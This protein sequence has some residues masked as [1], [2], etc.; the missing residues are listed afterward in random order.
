M[1]V[2]ITPAPL[3]GTI[4]AIPSKSHLHRLLICAALGDTELCLPCPKLSQDIEATV[5]C[6][7]AL[8]AKVK[9]QSNELSV[10]PIASS[11]QNVTLDCGE[12]GSLYRFLVPVIGALNKNAT[13]KLSGKLPERPM[14]ALWNTLEAHGAVITG[15]GTATPIV[16]GIL[17]SGRYEIP[18]DISSQFISGLLFALPLLS[19]DSEIVISGQTQSVGYIQMTLDALTAFS[20]KAIPTPT[21]FSIPGNQTYHAINT[22]IP[23]GDWSNSAFWLCAAACSGEIT[24]TGLNPNSGQGDKAICDILRQFG[25]SVSQID[26]AVTVR[27]GNLHGITIDAAD[28]PDLVPALA[29][30][31]AAADGTTT[32]QNI[33]RLRLKESDRV[34]TVCG[35]IN[36]LGGNA[37]S[38]EN[39]ITIIGNGT[40]TGGTY[41]AFQDHRIVMAAAIASTICK[42]PVTVTNAQAVDKSYPEFFSDFSRLNGICRER[43]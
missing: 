12:S 28:I 2:T 5:R 38:N 42:N 41:D 36:A 23:E 3:N 15:K 8:G 43:S 33:S 22:P 34:A 31:A 27:K 17:T 10:I 6:L 14:D 25:A 1:N 13:F 18:G 11:D 20:I 29:V 24:V 9:Y 16:S 7:N 4:A 35:L 40:L 30:V 21:G 32:I 37:S 19:G 26:N 39:T